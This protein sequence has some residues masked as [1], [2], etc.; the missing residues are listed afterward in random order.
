MRLLHTADW[1]LNDRLGRIDRTG[2]LRAAVERIAQYCMQERV[3]VLLVAGDLFSELA[4]PD[5]LRE[6]IRHWQEVFAE[7]LSQG[8]T[9]LTL[10]GNHDNENF[11]QT[12]CHAMTL[13]APTVGQPGAVVPAGRLYLAAEP[14]LLRLQD[15]QGGGEVQFFLLP[16]PTPTRY[17][18]GDGNP[19]YTSPEEKTR[20]LITAFEQTLHGVFADAA[21]RHDL[22]IV[23]GAHVHCYGSEVGPSLFRMTEAE[24]MLVHAETV[25]D[26]FA[27]V[28][29]G[30]IHKPQS[31][32]GKTHVRYSGS[33]ER[34]D[35]GEQHD[36]KGVVLVEIGPR[37]LLGEPVTLPLPATAIYEVTITDPPTE[38]PRLKA[39]YPDAEQDLV[40]L[41]LT[42][43]AGRDNLEAILREL[44]QLF[45]RW[46]ARDWRES[47]QLLPGTLAER[48]ANRGRSFAETVRQYLIQE[49]AHHPEQE[50]A[51]LLKLAE[52]LLQEC[53]N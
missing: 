10:T 28:A 39:E 49:L 46:Y 26:R 53:E 43:T 23:L 31:L 44:D 7:F 38:L 32:C 22:P 21:F 5:A 8:G 11:C 20:L 9:I 4:R 6:T 16:Y 51:E 37:G 40:N 29:L 52:E 12:L 2:D 48:T 24:D 42:Y 25:W 45:P 35:L 19:K 34:M 14:T 13:A 30:H 36:V 27:Y 47:R 33:I 3:D 17:L 41:H 50:R 18:R 15:R 1:H